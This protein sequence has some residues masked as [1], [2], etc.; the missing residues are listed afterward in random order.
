MIKSIELRD[1]KTHKSTSIEFGKGVNVL[2]GLMGAGKSSVMDAISFALFGTFPSLKHKRVT[3]DGII[4]N[5]PVQAENAEVS[6]TFTVG[7]NTYR[8]LRRISQKEGG[9]A[10][11]EK[12]GA[13]LQTQPERVNEEIESLLKIDYDTFSRAVYSEQ[14]RLDYFLEISK[15]DRKKEIDR[16]LGLDLFAT[17]E[18]NATSLVNSVRSLI[19]DEE[20]TLAS[21]DISSFR[22]QMDALV[23]EAKKMAQEQEA[24][25]RDFT[26][27]EKLHGKR[28]AEL[29][30]MKA[31]LA[32][33]QEL[34]NR[35]IQLRSSAG[36]IK[37][38]I[39]KIEEK[40]IDETA[41]R[42]ELADSMAKQE[43]ASRAINKARE[44]ERTLTKNLATCDAGIK[45]ARARLAEREKYAAM[46]KGKDPAK[47]SGELDDLRKRSKALI[48][49]GALFKS[50]AAETE[51][52]MRE[53]EKHVGQCPVC[54]R[55]LNEDLKSS[56]RKRRAGALDEIRAKLEANKPELDRCNSRIRELEKE[57]PEV[58]LAAGRM[59]ETEGVD[60]K[61]AELE[62]ERMS[63]KSLL[64]AASSSLKSASEGYEA[65]MKQYAGV[66]AREEELRRKEKY[67]DEIKRLDID[68]K[69]AEGELEG[70]KVDEK[71]IDRLQEEV[72][73]EGNAVA[74]MKAKA[75]ANKRYIESLDAQI[76]EKRKQIDSLAAIEKRIERRRS[77]LSSLNIFKAALSDTSTALRNRLVS[78]INGIM[79]GLW[80][81]LYPY[82]DYANIRLNAKRDDYMLEFD[83]Q[84]GAEELWQ[85][86]DQIASGGER[87][88]GCLTL[89]IALAMV[90]VPNLKWII[91]DEPTHNIDEAGIEKLIKVLQDSL[92]KVV[93][94]IFIITHD[95]ALREIGTARVYQLDRDKSVNEPTRVAEV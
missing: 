15:G 72:S 4:S 2:V 76:A 39:A 59:R 81:E 32:K 22:L 89:R 35:L 12:D 27:K 20:A 49:E 74:E 9:F 43:E 69:R 26:E 13:Y 1:W 66:K 88:I 3:L 31:L 30:D 28:S 10:R 33:G 87:S 75:T 17:A 78:S 21:M 80:P 51:E 11:L 56:I 65:V 70:I 25:V 18:E 58:S 82:G 7:G 79:S 5:R 41:V 42:K 48:E 68:T 52:L 61:L 95:N 37:A 8:V 50:K 91:L 90:I 71:A 84:N 86:V 67:L 94:Q 14:N 40:G 93:E 64:D 83:T 57:I 55:E 44:E 6:L 62:K 73:R 45:D 19:K 77:L 47:L 60:A 53:L 36:T 34:S 38:E 54:E 29:R 85:P 24:L 92:P 46:A 23:A 16:M 63:I